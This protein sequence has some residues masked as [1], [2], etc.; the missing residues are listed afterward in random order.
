MLLAVIIGML[1]NSYVM[2]ILEQP[3]VQFIRQPK[4]SLWLLGAL[5]EAVFMAAIS[6]VSFWKIRKFSLREIAEE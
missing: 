3:D 5:I 1:T 6:T 2:R 4:L